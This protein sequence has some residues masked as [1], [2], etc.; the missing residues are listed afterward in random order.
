MYFYEINPYNILI[1]K[2]EKNSK[3]LYRLI[4]FES[5]NKFLEFNQIFIYKDDLP[6]LP[7]TKQFFCNKNNNLN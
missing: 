7:P 4:N 2:K 5:E 3:K 1:E 6:F